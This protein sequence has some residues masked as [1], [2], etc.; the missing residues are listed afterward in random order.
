M[1]KRYFMMPL[2]GL[3]VTAGALL[4]AGISAGPASAAA[5]NGCPATKAGV[6]VASDVTASHS[7]S[8]NVTTY[9]F[10]SLTG[11]NPSGGV[12]GLIKY[13][14][15]PTSPTG[16]PQSTNVVAKGDNHTNWITGA[17]G[18]NFAFMRPS[19][20]P[21]N[22]GLDGQSHT[23][24]IATWANINAVPDNQA[25]V[26]HVNDPAMCASLYGAG[27]STCFVRP[28]PPPPPG[29]ICD[30]G[31]SNV[32]YNAMPTNVA[33]CINPAEGFEANSV[34][35]MG[36]SVA[37]ATG[38]GRTLDTLRVDLQD[39]ACGTSGH[40]SGT[41]QDAANQPSPCLT[42]PGATFDHPITANIYAADASGLPGALLAT[43]TETKT[44][45]YRPSADPS[46]PA[47]AG[48]HGWRGV[49]QPGERTAR[50]PSG[51]C[52]ASTAGCPRRASTALCPTTW[53]GR[54]RSAPRTTATRRWVTPLPAPW[55]WQRTTS[56]P[57][58]GTTRST[59]GTRP[60]P[61]RPTP[62]PLS[63]RIRSSSTRAPVS[64]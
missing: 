23:M 12:P 52:S 39:F 17:G 61:T 25:V 22:I 51:P 41:T 26:L 11:Q 5:S 33:D 46:C 13:C 44:I 50:T 30:H 2:A 10:T 48:T 43:D 34:S 47:N 42:V 19:G 63:I 14:V 58:A 45:P 37:L 7:T 55:P 18:N 36:D 27:T 21:S 3:A 35:E 28:S 6:P 20:N 4:S 29:P 38:T 16:Q 62:G 24:G 54:S 64:R 60:T 53:S 57:A 56:S 32:A 31:D 49:V 15:Y 59:S 9:K 1:R 8:G 40:W